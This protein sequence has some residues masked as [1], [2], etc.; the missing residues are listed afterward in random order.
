MDNKTL[1]EI[2]DKYIDD[3][4]QRNPS[5]L[6]QIATIAEKQW[7]EEWGER[8]YD[9]DPDCACC[10]AWRKFDEQWR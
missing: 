10:I 1:D 7:L 6:S 9:Y 2:L 5:F 8:C 3:V 4:L